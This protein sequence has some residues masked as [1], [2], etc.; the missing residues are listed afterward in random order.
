MAYRTNFHQHITGVYD[1]GIDVR[2]STERRAADMSAFAGT[3][4]FVIRSG[5]SMLQTYLTAAELRELATAAIAA[6]IDLDQIDRD[7]CMGE[8]A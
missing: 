6:A 7:I 4:T 2:I 8:A 3:A 5:A 1:T